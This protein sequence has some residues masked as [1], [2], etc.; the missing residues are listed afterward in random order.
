MILLISDTYYRHLDGNHKLIRWRFVVHG[1]IDGFS[2]TVVFLKVAPN[3]LSSTVLDLFQSATHVFHY[4]RRIRTDHGTENVAVAREMLHRYGPSSNPVI[5]GQ[6]VHNQRIERLWR[7]VFTF[8]LTYY[9]NIF[10]YLESQQMLNPDDEVHVYAL[11][12]I[13]L[14]RINKALDHF[15]SQWNNHP[16]SSLENL[17]QNMLVEYTKHFTKAL[18]FVLI[19]RFNRFSCL[20]DNYR[21]SKQMNNGT[22]YVNHC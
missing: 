9:K 19:F 12:Y 8:V 18:Y 16:L 2:R 7:D 6:S 17:E 11:Q 15:V 10:Y 3:N 20:R 21:K 5:T 14:P 1:G 13:Y 22:P 4:P